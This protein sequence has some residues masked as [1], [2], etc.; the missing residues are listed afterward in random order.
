MR[1]G[2]GRSSSCF[3]LSGRDWEVWRGQTGSDRE[4]GISGTEA[5]VGK[6]C[7]KGACG[8]TRKN[9]DEL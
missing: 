4:T 2:T 1:D 9:E 3:T 7:T 6:R 8:G 5:I